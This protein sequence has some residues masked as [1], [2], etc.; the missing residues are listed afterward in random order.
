MKIL[1]ILIQRFLAKNPK[2]ATKIQVA[3]LIV[4]AILELP[5]LLSF[6]EIPVPEWW[7]AISHR[8]GALLAFAA[9]LGLQFTV[10]SS[11]ST[12]QKKSNDDGL[13]DPEK[14]RPPKPTNP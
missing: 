8:L 5:E 6:L 7:G 4:G 2:V 10:D 12:I 3:L 11:Q 1:T 9:T 13:S 14:P